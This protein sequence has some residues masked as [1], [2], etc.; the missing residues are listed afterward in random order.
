MT[1]EQK[2]IAAT[3]GAFKI[4]MDRAFEQGLSPEQFVKMMMTEKE[5]FSSLVDSC[6]SE[7]K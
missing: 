7:L 3:V 5:K 2:A 6:K 4:A 1:N